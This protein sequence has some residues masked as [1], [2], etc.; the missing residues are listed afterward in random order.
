MNLGA[1]YW[2]FS[3]RMAHI[4]A[5]F[6]RAAESSVPRDCVNAHV[7]SRE[8]AAILLQDQWNVFCR[9][10][11]VSSWRGGVTTLSGTHLPVRSGRRSNAQA[12]KTLR[13]TYTGRLKKPPY[14][15][16]KW[17]DAGATIDAAHRLAIPNGLTW[18]PVSVRLRRLSMSC[19]PSEITSP[20]RGRETSERLA[21]YLPGPVSDAAAHTFISTTT[22][23]GAAL[24]ELW[25][26]QLDSMARVS[27]A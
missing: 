24:L 26:A 20:T 9:D 12:M 16:P 22:L 6:R 11:V 4:S 7:L 18:S 13:A 23:G 1:R 5:A 14:W 17:F 15:E 19:E 25:A 21:P 8:A 27:V 10:L 3:E 2:R